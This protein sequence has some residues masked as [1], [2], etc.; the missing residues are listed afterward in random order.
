[1]RILTESKYI[2]TIKKTFCFNLLA[3]ESVLCLVTEKLHENIQNPYKFVSCSYGGTLYG[4]IL[5]SYE[6]LTV[7]WCSMMLCI[8]F[9]MV[10][11]MLPQSMLLT[12]YIV[13]KLKYLEK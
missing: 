13:V 8:Q 4:C 11:C 2:S 3:T 6:P 5:A 1:M 12:L 10:L 9:S 7:Q